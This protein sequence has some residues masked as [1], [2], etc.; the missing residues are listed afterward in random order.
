M[1]QRLTQLAQLAR[2]FEKNDGDEPMD[3]VVRRFWSRTRPALGRPVETEG[4][5]VD[6]SE[7]AHA[8][9][10]DARS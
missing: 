2:L 3:V 4:V 5:V 7:W 1:R 8:R 6:L 10:K 9:G